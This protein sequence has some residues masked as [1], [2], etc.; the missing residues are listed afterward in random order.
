MRSFDRPRFHLERKSITHAPHEVTC[1]SQTRSKSRNSLRAVTRTNFGHS[2]E[3]ILRHLS[4]VSA[5]SEG[6]ESA[7]RFANSF[8]L[9]LF[10]SGHCNLMPSED[11]RRSLL[12][13]QLIPTRWMV[14]EGSTFERS[15]HAMG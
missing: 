10:A 1:E 3:H 7:I 14:S 8:Q 15:R 13:K 12:R 2:E 4:L 5:S 6:S 9:N 11:S